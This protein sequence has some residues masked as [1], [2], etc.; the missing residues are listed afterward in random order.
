[1]GKITPEQKFKNARA[2]KVLSAPIINMEK[3]LYDSREVEK[4]YEAL[5]NAGFLYISNHGVDKNLIQEIKRVSADFY[6]LSPSKRK[7]LE[8]YEGKL[9]HDGSAFSLTPFNG[10]VEK[11]A[12]I[13][14]EYVDSLF[15]KYIGEITSL[16]LRLVS[17]FEIALGLKKGRLL[18]RVEPHGVQNALCYERTPPKK[19]GVP[20][21]YDNG[22]LTILMQDDAGGLQ[23][24]SKD[25]WFSIP[26]VKDT[27]VVN[28]GN[29]L[30]HISLDEF[31]WNAHNL[32]EI[33]RKKKAKG[34]EFEASE[35]ETFKEWFFVNVVSSEK[36]LDDIEYGKIYHHV[37]EMVER[38]GPFEIGAFN[39][40]RKERE[41]EATVAETDGSPSNHPSFYHF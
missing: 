31:K 6:H 11:D 22:F 21:H 2:K 33:Q 35:D 29:M 16:A 37:W 39:E 3:L 24:M 10:S 34:K 40:F 30:E 13:D 9:V 41:T 38:D 27:F 36:F 26:P 5:V 23:A 25:E 1:M 7:E 28:F 15:H 12:C 8:N 14:I 4:L 20:G 18:N 17:F 32:P 19:W